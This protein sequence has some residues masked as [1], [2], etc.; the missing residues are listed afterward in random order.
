LRS[1][2]VI[3]YFLPELFITIEKM[4][5][6]KPHPA[7]L[8]QWLSYVEFED[9]SDLGPEGYAEVMDRVDN[10]I[11]ERL[12]DPKNPITDVVVMLKGAIPKNFEFAGEYYRRGINVSFAV[13][14]RQDGSAA[15]E[16][17]DGETYVLSGDVKGDHVLIFDDIFDTTDSTEGTIDA[18]KRQQAD[19][20][21]EIKFTV[22]SPFLKG[23]IKAPGFYKADAQDILAGKNIPVFRIGD[24]VN[25]DDITDKQVVYYYGVKVPG[26]WIDTGA[27]MGSDLV[28]P[29]KKREVGMFDVRLRNQTEVPTLDELVSMEDDL[30]SKFLARMADIEALERMTPACITGPIED[31]AQYE[32]VL[33]NLIGKENV[34]EDT[35][36][37]TLYSVILAQFWRQ[38]E[39]ARG[40]KSTGSLIEV[41]GNHAQGLF[42]KAA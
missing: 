29:Q 36:Y 9:G 10:F 37:R 39:E 1:Q 16:Y 33:I 28:V 41:M 5:N 19:R 31:M 18:V 11:M 35:L 2:S 20:A 6:E 34:K 22:V 14:Q 30:V 3:N 8:P 42:S 23:E 21:E 7:E 26:V 38:V 40:E 25:P 13:K 12:D 15:S 24:N 32:E 17:G 4:S 27:G